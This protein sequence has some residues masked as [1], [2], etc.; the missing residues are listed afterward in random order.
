[1][2]GVL[3]LQVRKGDVD[4]RQL[5]SILRSV[6]PAPYGAFLS[7]GNGGPQ[8]ATTYKFPRVSLRDPPNGTLDAFFVWGLFAGSPLSLALRQL[9]ESCVHHLGLATHC[10]ATAVQSLS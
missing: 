1:V 4:A 3:W 2:G 8:V 5:Y 10:V 6:N 9:S 7:F